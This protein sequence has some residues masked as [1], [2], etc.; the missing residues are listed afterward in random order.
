MWDCLWSWKLELASL[1]IC[2]CFCLKFLRNIKTNFFFVFCVVFAWNSLSKFLSISHTLHSSFL[3]FS[4]FSFVWVFSVGSIQAEETGITRKWWNCFNKI[5][6]KTT[7]LKNVLFVRGRAEKYELYS[8]S[9]ILTKLLLHFTQQLKILFDS[10]KNSFSL[11][12]LHFDSFIYVMPSLC[13]FL[14]VFSA[15]I[16]CLF[17]S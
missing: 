17:V 6:Y 2:V 12:F 7:Q 4:S 15:I 16:C 11:S 9:T 14:P 3:S 5:K 10:L 8:L 1:E 13:P